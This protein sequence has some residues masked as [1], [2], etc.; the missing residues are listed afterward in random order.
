MLPRPRRARQREARPEDFG[1]CAWTPEGHRPQVDLSIGGRLQQRWEGGDPQASWRVAPGSSPIRP[2]KRHGES[3]L[4]LMILD[5]DPRTAALVGE[6]D[7]ALRGDSA[8]IGSGFALRDGDGRLRIRLL[9]PSLLQLIGGSHV[10]L[11]SM[12]VPADPGHRQDDLG[13]ERP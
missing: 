13:K 8:Q 12:P 3:G 9:P 1:V 5:R 7:I 6:V 11:R 2:S 10:W 4:D